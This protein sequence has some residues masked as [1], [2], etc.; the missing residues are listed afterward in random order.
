MNEHQEIRAEALRMALQNEFGQKAIDLAQAY[1]DFMTGKTALP[2]QTAYPAAVQ[3][4]A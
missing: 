3:Q 4:A 1:Y 2:P